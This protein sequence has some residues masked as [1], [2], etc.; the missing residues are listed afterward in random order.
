MKSVKVI[1]LNISEKKG[2]I[3]SPVGQFMINKDGII[4][5]AHAGTK[6]RQVSLLGQN[7]IDKF[8]ASSGRKINFGDFAENIT[9]D[10]MPETIAP[11]DCFEKKGLILQVSQI[12]KKCHGTNCAIFTETGD[13]IMPKEGIFCKVLN[14]GELIVNDELDYHPRIFDIRIITL[15]DRASR[16]EYKDL[17]GEEIRILMNAFMEEKKRKSTITNQLIPDEKDILKKNILQIVEQKPDI[18]FT[19]G[20]T[21]IGPRDITPDVVRPMFDK[22]I[23]GIMEFIRL[24]YG[25]DNPRALLSRSIA[26]IIGKTLVYC[27]PG[28][29]KGVKEYLVEIQKTIIHSIYMLNELDIH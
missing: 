16:G 27:L 10:L 29:V 22:E 8:E 21:G 28:S 24:K 12:G 13:C 23:P 5:D 9:L 26:G 6:N 15:S 17:S 4:G 1:S 25:A 2:V 20:G 19:T 11:L 18:I 7:S 14:G 3:K